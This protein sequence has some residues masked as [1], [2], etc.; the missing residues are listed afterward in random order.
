MNYNLSSK[1][2]ILK[3]QLIKT[4]LPKLQKRKHV[5]LFRNELIRK[6]DN[7]Y[8]FNFK[9]II[10]HENLVPLIFNK[11][12][13]RDYFKFNSLSKFKILKKIL[14]LL[15][16]LFFF[17]RVRKNI[18]SIN[19]LIIV[20]DRHSENYFHWITDVLPKIF[21]LRQNNF[22]KKKKIFL[23]KFKNNFQKTT[24]NEITN[25]IQPS[26]KNKNIL[27]QNAYYVQEFH[28]SGAPRL[29]YLL[30]T[31]KFFI[32][33]FRCKY[34]GQKI[35]ISRSKSNRRKLSNEKDLIHQLKKRNFK[36]LYMEK[37]S[38]KE[39]VTQCAK[40]KLIISSHG[41]GLTNLIWM[42]RKSKII[43]IRDYSDESLNPF[44]ILCQRM[45]IEYN[46][47]LAKKNFK[48]KI[49]P[50]NDYEINVNNFIK[51]HERLLST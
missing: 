48:N 22:L 27:I 42:K 29:K 41:A 8:L 1:K 15:N 17:I 44:F 21:W 34:G 43:E 3:S 46:Y 36:I 28:P 16:F 2:K 24:L 38:F 39:Q 23:P 9:K 49:N 51:V 6:I 26:I 50:H 31:K 33:K 35:Y 20:H 5:K 11:E 4:K 30:E 25:I 10:L 47:Y 19:N 32:N 45:G 7:V 13:I 37:L 12:I 40:S 14:L 18:K